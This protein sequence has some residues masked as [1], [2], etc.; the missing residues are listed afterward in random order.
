MSRSRGRIT[1]RSAVQPETCAA[2]AA[3]VVDIRA[4]L[5]YWKTAYRAS[6]FHAGNRSFADYLP[7]L[8]FAYDAYFLHS[9][10]PLAML[11]PALQHKYA[12][13]LPS[14]A[15]LEW[16]RM[17]RVIVAVWLRLM[18]GGPHDA[19]AKTWH[20]SP[21]A[22]RKTALRL[23]RTVARLQNISTRD[24]AV[25]PVQAAREAEDS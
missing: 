4:E 14:R 16:P 11:L 21:G 6:G 18:R 15:R 2:D 17:T 12:E 5:A 13:A 10:Q 7:S 24:S 22:E 23:S 3:M 1:A 19:A 9:R 8:K 25:P 20:P